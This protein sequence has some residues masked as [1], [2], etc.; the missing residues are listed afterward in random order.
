[1][2]GKVEGKKQ[3]KSK[4]EAKQLS[5]YEWFLKLFSFNSEKHLLKT[6]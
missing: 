2:R 5:Q 6:F 4:A 3:M 1:M